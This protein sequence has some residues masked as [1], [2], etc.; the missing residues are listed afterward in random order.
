MIKERRHVNLDAELLFCRYSALRSLRKTENTQLIL[1]N[2]TSGEFAFLEHEV[3]RQNRMLYYQ[4]LNKVLFADDIGEDEL[5]DFM[6]PFDMRLAPLEELSS[7]DAFRQEPVR[8]SW[9]SRTQ[10]RES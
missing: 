9:P 1:Q 7:I 5:L 3:H 10:R 8:V 4:T 6:K 2:H